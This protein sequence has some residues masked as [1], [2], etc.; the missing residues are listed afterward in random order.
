MNYTHLTENER[1]MISAL[2]KQGTTVANIA[3]QLGRH[4]STIYREVE[5]NARYCGYNK[6]YSYQ[7]ARAQ[8]RARTRLSYSRRNK[9]YDKS[10]FRLVEALLRL[11]WSPDQV[12]GYLR[13]RGYPT[14][15]HELIYQHV[16]Q[17]K[18]G[19]GTLWKHL[20]QSTKMRRKRYNSKDSRGRLASKRHITERPVAAKERKEPGHWEIDTVVGRGT[21]HCIVTLVDR[22]TG[23]TF[24]GQLDDRTTGSLNIRMSKIMSRSSL[25]FKTITADNGTEFHQYAQL[26]RF[27]NCLFYFANPYHSWERGTNENTNGLIRQYLPKRTSMSHVTQKLCNEIAHKLNTR[28]R[29][30]LGYRTPT[31]Y[32]Y[33]HL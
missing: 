14:M 19:G 9:R 33:A 22:M 32:I 5:R 7:P 16:W 29:K 23:Y 11:E 20:R 3:I 4:K 21:K 1:Y 31:E 12:V 17:D 8:Q 28:P 27:H 26:E 6:R 25:P 10:D 24:I 13:L 30:R 15:S 18:A 2:R